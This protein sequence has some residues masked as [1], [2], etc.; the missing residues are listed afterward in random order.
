MFLITR[1]VPKADSGV[2][3]AVHAVLLQAPI[4][5]GLPPD[6]VSD[7]L[8]RVHPEPVS[9]SASIGPSE[10]PGLAAVLSLDR[11]PRHLEEVKLLL[12]VDLDQGGVLHALAV[13]LSFIQVVGLRGI[14]Q[15]TS[16]QVLQ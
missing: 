7:R 4:W 13:L 6:E 15:E 2:D 1:N 12:G 16:W 10:P 5:L 9:F 3:R 14:E 8:E 11:E